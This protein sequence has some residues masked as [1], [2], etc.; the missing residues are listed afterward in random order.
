[1]NTESKH[2]LFILTALSIAMFPHLVWLPA[3]IIFW[4]FLFFVYSFQVSRGKWR[5]PKPG[6]RQ[7]LTVTGFLAVL[8]A[9]GLR[10][11]R[12]S[13]VGLLAVMSGLKALEIKTDRDRTISV[14][15]AYFIVLSNL[16]HSDSLAMTLYMLLSVSVTT[17]ALISL[18]DRKSRV[19]DHLRLAVRMM[20][21]AFPIM[22]VCFFLFPRLQ[23]GL[24]GTVGR[25]TAKIGFS[26]TLAPGDI[27]KI[28]RNDD[29]A[30]RAT[31]HDP[32]PKPD[33]LY[34][35]GLVL[36]H[37]DGKTWHRGI[38]VPYRQESADGSEA[39]S[40]T[41]SLEP[42]GKR[43]RFALDI[44]LSAPPFVRLL[45]DHTLISRRTVKRRISYTLQS[46]TVYQTGPLKPWEEI[47]RQLPTDGN[48]KAMALA[49]Q[50]AGRF[51]RPQGIV[52]AATQ[53]FKENRFIYTLEPPLLKASNRIDD[54]LFKTRKGYCEHFASA[55]AFLMRAAQ[56][57][58]R[59][60]VGYLGGEK[61]P[62]GNYLIVR[63]SDAHAWVEVWLPAKGWTRIDPTT[64][65]VPERIEQGMVVALPEGERPAYLKFTS[66]APVFRSW[67][68]IQLGWDA[69]NVH[70][71]RWVIGYTRNRQKQVF[72][73]LGI[74]ATSL[75]GI[76]KTMLYIL[77]AI[78]IF[79]ILFLAGRRIPGGGQK[80][81]V[82]A[83]YSRFCRKLGN[84]G[85]YRNPAQGPLDF[86]KY[87]EMTRKDLTVEANEITQLYIELR[88]GRGVGKAAS[89]KLKSMIK[90]FKPPKKDPAPRRIDP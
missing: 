81:P 26:D 17:G 1:M 18:N 59:V 2:H 15:L 39:V 13:C 9:F 48:P 43:W 68:K 53:Y 38:R 78:G 63:Q 52:D 19:S 50:W 73:N 82:Q 30:F 70:W 83:S 75:T 88:Y 33:R 12:E 8:L 41:V 90:R 57:P 27:S 34:W 16:L 44:P 62:F 80:D 25:S 47:A 35:R 60:V 84:V 40:Y 79:A 67:K 11:D 5:R 28:A 69:T 20:I 31:F 45:D 77:G 51:E 87:V 86:A 85:V 21:Q 61:N 58:A 72:F 6:V 29:V 42:H 64:A 3:W 4:C 55:F 56:I 14:F 23:G 36:W 54:F 10:I 37:F 32:L 65:V 22:L 24:W 71:N 74:G 89:Q 66:L 76:F 7:L 49:K 46:Y